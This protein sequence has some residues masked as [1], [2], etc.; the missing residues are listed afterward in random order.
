VVVNHSGGEL[1]VNGQVVTRFTPDPFQGTSK[2][3]FG[4]QPSVHLNDWTGQNIT[5]SA[6]A[7]YR[8][9]FTQDVQPNSLFAGID[10]PHPSPLGTTVSNP[11]ML[12]GF[13]TVDMRAEWRGFLGAR[14]DLAL[15]VTN[16]LNKR[17]VI[18][19][20]GLTT[21]AGMTPAT[22]NEPRMIYLEASYSF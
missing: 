6:N 18:G 2:W 5:I 15:Q 19:T 14:A 21:V 8:S 10:L 16:L 3:R 11:L 17:A 1:S 22:I 13:T 9:K 12:P 20:S 7:Y 4:V